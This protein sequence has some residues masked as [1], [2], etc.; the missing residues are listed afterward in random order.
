MWRKRAPG[1]VVEVIPAC[2]WPLGNNVRAGD[3]CGQGAA[4]S[5]CDFPSAS[6]RHSRSWRALWAGTRHQ[7]SVLDEGWLS[8]GMKDGAQSWLTVKSEAPDQERKAKLV[9]LTNPCTL[10]IERNRQQIRQAASG[11]EFAS[12]HPCPSSWLLNFLSSLH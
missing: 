9:R 10:T 8:P 4:G 2:Y 5:T 1:K 7:N 3:E 6:G 11:T 12:G